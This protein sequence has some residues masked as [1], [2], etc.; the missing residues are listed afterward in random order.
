MKERNNESEKE[1]NVSFMKSRMQIAKKE[2]NCLLYLNVQ[3]K[4]ATTIWFF[5]ETQR[6]EA[7]ILWNNKRK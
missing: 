7:K 3:M 4:E 2:G 6:I 5:T 1:E